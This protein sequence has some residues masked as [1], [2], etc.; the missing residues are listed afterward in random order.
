MINES[1]L[2]RLFKVGSS[3]SIAP[4]KLSSSKEASVFPA[5]PGGKTT[6][7]LTQFLY[8]VTSSGFL[9]VLFK[10][11]R[12]SLWYRMIST[13]CLKISL[14]C[15][16]IESYV[17]LVLSYVCRGTRHVLSYCATFFCQPSSPSFLI[18]PELHHFMDWR[19][20]GIFHLNKLNALF[21]LRT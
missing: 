11:C 17:Y 16:V 2:G 8:K 20:L 10:T 3:S 7:A 21:R 6:D 14:V 13:A 18:P 1:K 15:C 9:I 4:P 12:T 5:A 19:T